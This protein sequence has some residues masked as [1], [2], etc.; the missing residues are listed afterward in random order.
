MS[1]LTNA[2]N[3][4]GGQIQRLALARA[5]LKDAQVYFFDESTS[6]IDIESE[7]VILDL[8]QEL[9]QHKTIIMVSHRLANATL[10]DKIYVLEKGHIAEQGTHSQLI[11]QNGLYTE[12]FNQQASLEKIR[13]GGHYA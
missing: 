3:L 1:L 4:S 6:N 2:S 5:L 13:N 9:K 10:A 8:I 12:M 11:Q 7:K